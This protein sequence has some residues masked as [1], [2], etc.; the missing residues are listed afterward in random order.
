MLTRTTQ[1]AS[2]SELPAD[3]L[4]EY[5][6]IIDH[7]YSKLCEERSTQIEIFGRLFPNEL[8]LGF[9][10][11]D[12]SGEKS[13]PYSLLLSYDVEGPE[14][15]KSIKKNSLDMAAHFLDLYFFQN[16]KEYIPSWVPETFNKLKFYYKI[17]REDF[18]LTLKADELLAQSE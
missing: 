8:L 12:S 11:R 1:D 13:A 4:A 17:T 7:T 14:Q 5:Q 15:L 9:S 16:E 18:L 3:W 10:I 2:G 6:N